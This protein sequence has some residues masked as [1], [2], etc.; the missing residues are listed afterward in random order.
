[1]ARRIHIQ[2]IDSRNYLFDMRIKY[3]LIKCEFV[4][5]CILYIKNEIAR[6]PLNSE[7]DAAALETVYLSIFK[8]HVL[9]TD[10]TAV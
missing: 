7:R 8:D 3:F 2:T 5:S 6:H 10:L 4:R 1:M 9:V